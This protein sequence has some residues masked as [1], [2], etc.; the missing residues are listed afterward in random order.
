VKGLWALLPLFDFYFAEGTRVKAFKGLTG[1]N[2]A[3]QLLLKKWI[4]LANF[5]FY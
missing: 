1:F 4:H 3:D 2:F 5:G